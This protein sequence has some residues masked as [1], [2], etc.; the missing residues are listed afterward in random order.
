[1]PDD[2]APQHP[3]TI[4]RP[5]GAGAP[6]PGAQPTAGADN[7]VLGEEIARGGMG[8]ILE[9]EDTKLRRTVAAKLM[10][11]DS[12]TDE[13]IKQRFLREAEVLALLAHPNIVPIHDIVWEDGVP[14]FYTMKRVNGRTLQAILHDLRK[15]DA[16]ALRDFTLDRLLLVFRKVCDALACAHSKGII[17][18]DLKP[19]N[20]MIGEFGEVLVMDWGLAKTRAESGERK[21]ESESAAGNLSALRSPLSALN[22]LQGSVMGTPQ[23]MSPE[24]A[25]GEIDSL[26]ERSDIFSL[27]GILYAIL[28]LRPPVDG[29]TLDEVLTKVRSAVIAPLDLPRRHEGTKADKTA[30]SFVSSSLRGYLPG[31]RIP[32]ALASVVM[33]ALRLDPAQRYQSVAEFSADIEAYQ[34]GFATKAE[35]AGL[36]TQLVLLIKRNKAVFSTAAAA[37]LLI[38]VLAVWFVINL[39]AKEQRAVAGEA[40]AL[41]E[42]EAARRALAASQAA[43]A[44]AAFRSADLPAMVLALD[45]VPPDLRDQRWDYLSAKRDSSLGD[46]H[47]EGLA[48]VTVIA[49]IPGH[50]AQFAIA[51]GR[52]VIGIV[53]VATGKTLRTI[54]TKLRD[55]VLAVSADGSRIAATSS[56][57]ATI[58]FYR[59]ADGSGDGTVP[60]PG[61]GITRLSF[62]ADGTLLAVLDHS[63]KAQQLCL[64]DARGGAVRWRRPGD[65][66]DAVFSPDG[67]RLFAGKAIGRSLDIIGVEKGDVIRS[68][69][70]FLNSMALSRDGRR[71]A[72][73]LRS[74]EV[75]IFDV[76]TGLETQ[77]ARLHLSRI[78]GLTW[79]A[80]DLLLTVGGEG[81]T[82]KGRRVMRLWETDGF[83]ARGTFFGIEEGAIGGGW[84]FN[85]ESGHLLM[86]QDTPRLWHIPAGVEAAR[87]TGRAERGWG[88]G[89]ISDTVLLARRD[90][91]LS[92]FDV[93][94]PRAPKESPHASPRGYLIVAPCWP[95][96]LVAL[97]KRTGA[98]PMSVKIYGTDGGGLVEQRDLP[99]PGRV[100]QMDWDAAG[101]RLLAVG[102]EPGAT[103]FEVSTGAT[104]LT[105]PQAIKQAVF[106]GA[107][108]QVAAIISRKSDADDVQDDLALLDATTGQ[109][110][111]TVPFHQRLNA[112]A[113]SPDR[114]LV[115][116]GGADMI[117]RVLDAATLEERFTYR[118]H[119][120][121]ISALAFHPA[122]PILVTGSPDGS[123]KLWDYATAHLRG[124]FLGF[125]GAPVAIAFSPNGRLLSVES[126]EPTGRLFDLGEE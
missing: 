121:E 102:V 22:T 1:M 89:F 25:R 74:G 2:D 112:L 11:F 101:G 80:G 41:V 114:R 32:A 83:L 115:A 35:Q 21:P 75:A 58:R 26:D 9:A 18:R 48:K 99:T 36:A 93:T 91:A 42:K 60:A 38:T 40:A 113:V 79:T 122:R 126:A 78:N 57:A 55:V 34:A 69:D 96:G 125:A 92:S 14:L 29:A 5:S 24:Q 39:R 16:A 4:D 72:L 19:E 111:K 90:F 64:V 28:T 119:D 88:T 116:I 50:A 123:V 56:G 87:F 15:E 124:T 59:V 3:T 52:G 6:S 109:P 85:P 7:Y 67:T 106:T 62:S 8:Y 82:G 77:R 33:K 17:H 94:D 61:A 43:L 103:I 13:G 104:L 97:A 51:D 45:S 46:F 105:L 12:D 44:E 63:P 49:T 108:G 23:Y 31:G 120:A 37:W 95:A 118:A 66:I 68:Q 27:G 20:F 30:A 110:L 54:A 70:V 73:G 10:I 117:V 47:V 71:L 53:D 86:G 107:S 65:Y 98:A 84:S 81:E 100:E 76:A